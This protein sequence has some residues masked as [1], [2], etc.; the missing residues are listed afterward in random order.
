VLEPCTLERKGHTL[1]VK[2][3]KKNVSFPVGELRGIVVLSG[4]AEMTARLVAFLM[5]KGIPIALPGTRCV[6]WNAGEVDPAVFGRKGVPDGVRVGTR[7]SL[8]AIDAFIEARK[9]NVPRVSNA[10]EGAKGAREALARA[11]WALL[12]EELSRQSSC[13][14]G[15]SR[16]FCCAV[17]RKG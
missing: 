2:A 3:H 11:L 5:G 1:A 6:L 13:S 9:A 14:T 15:R 17:Y 7:K 10:R 12:G 16:G 4:M 8:K